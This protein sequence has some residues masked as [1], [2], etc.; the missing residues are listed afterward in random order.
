MRDPQV[1]DLVHALD[2]ELSAGGYTEDQT[3]GYPPEKLERSAVH[4][5]GARTGQEHGGHLV[6]IGGVELGDDGTAELKRMYVAPHARGNGA[7]DAILAALV[8]HAR[9]HGVR[10]LRLETGDQQH[11]AL[12]FYRRHGFVEIP[13]FPP[14]VDSAT[15]VCMELVLR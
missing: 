7:A 5:V 13:R 9:E 6:G 2:V 8:E 14:Y 3:F 11:A 1:L 10:A 12:A 15:S 4:L